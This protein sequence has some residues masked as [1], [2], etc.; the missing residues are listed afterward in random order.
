MRTGKS[1]R[2]SQWEKIWFLSYKAI[3]SMHLKLHILIFHITCTGCCGEWGRG[4]WA[5]H[6]LI[7]GNRSRWGALAVCSG[8]V[9]S[10]TPDGDWGKI[11]LL[12]SNP[13]TTPAF[14]VIHIPHLWDLPSRKVTGLLLTL[15]A[16]NEG[17]CCIALER[18]NSL[19]FVT[20]VG[21]N[22]SLQRG[23]IWN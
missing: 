5:L 21:Q 17:I 7:A 15:I 22:S 6:V 12:N 3:K 19:E 10:S 4:F 13:M 16:V 9:W 8:T 14:Y 1:C 20:W 18:Q 11:I 2:E 23:L